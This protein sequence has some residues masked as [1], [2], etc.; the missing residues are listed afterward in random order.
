MAYEDFQDLTR[1]TAFCTVLGDKAFNIAKY[2]KYGW[3]QRGL[4][5]KLY[6]FF[7]KKSSDGDVL[8]NQELKE[9]LQKPMIKKFEKQ[10]V[11]SSFID[12]IWGVLIYQICN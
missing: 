11:H 4:A 3:Y 10:K 9:E 5:S 8:Q 1:I 12:S 6:I 2:P 7:D